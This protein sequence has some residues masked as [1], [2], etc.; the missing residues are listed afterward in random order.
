MRLGPIL[1][2]LL[3]V[4]AAAAVPAIPADAP[5]APPGIRLPQRPAPRL[6]L[7]EWLGDLIGLHGG[8][9]TAPAR[10]ERIHLNLLPF[11]VT[12]P[13]IGAGAGVAALGAVRLGDLPT[14]S[15]STFTVSGLATTNGQSSLNVRSDVRLPRNDWILVGDWALSH[16][17]NPAWGVGGDTPDRGR[18]TLDRRQVKLHETAYRRLAGHLYGGAGYYLDDYF[19]IVDRRAASG[20]ATAVSAYGIGTSGRSVSSGLAGSLLWDSRDNPIAPWRGQY[21]LVR[22]RWAPDEF[23]SERTWQSLWLEARTYVPLPRRPDNIALWAFGWFAFGRTPYLMLPSI[24]ID[25]EQRSGRG[26]VEARHVGRDLLGAEAEYRFSLW[27]F[28][29]G[30]VGANVHSVS[31]REPLEGEPEFRRW[32]PAAVAG[33][34]LTLDRRSLAALA[35]DL[36]VAPGGVSAYVSFNEA[37]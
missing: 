9:E 3:G 12:N 36:A 23:G 6:D 1:S 15:Y 32:H 33:L 27:E 25:P 2:L 8:V 22:Y 21:A 18:T 29:G 14:T 7:P 13:L 16:F 34:R 30:V 4:R 19:D 35:V 28:V 24:G 26:Y 10:G 5:A 37:F 11:V 31:D 20:E 17:P